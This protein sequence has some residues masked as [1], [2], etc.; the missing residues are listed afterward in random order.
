VDSDFVSGF[1]RP[2][3]MTFAPDGRLFVTEKDGEVKVVKNGSLLGTPFL[4]VSVTN[5]NSSGL[6]GIIFDPDFIN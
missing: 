2:T 6:N 5:D 1:D 3:T 4:S